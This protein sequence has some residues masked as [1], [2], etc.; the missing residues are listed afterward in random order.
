MVVTTV[1]AIEGKMSE[2]Q[3]LKTLLPKEL[4]GWVAIKATS[5]VNPSLIRSVKVDKVKVETQIDVI[6]WERMPVQER[7]LLFWHEVARIQSNTVYKDRWEI[8]ILAIALGSTVVEIWA[9]NILLLSSA[10]LLSGM[11]GYRLYQ[12]HRG[13][14][15]LREATAADSNAITLATCFGYTRPQAYKALAGALKA[16][17]AQTPQQRQQTNYAVRLQVLKLNAAK[18]KAT[19]P[20]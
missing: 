13:E 5:E 9:Q 4:Q 6:R 12:R 16:L 18:A 20:H 11:I 17:I 3:R 2:Q 14:R 7:D 8:V 19:V 15:S 10:L 1:S